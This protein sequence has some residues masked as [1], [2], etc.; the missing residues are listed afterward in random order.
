MRRHIIG[1]AKGLAIAIVAAIVIVGIRAGTADVRFVILIAVLVALL[2]SGSLYDKE[3]PTKKVPEDAGYDLEIVQ[4]DDFGS[5]WDARHAEHV[6]NRID[7]LSRTQNVFVVLFIH[8][9]HNN[10]SPRNG[11]LLDFEEA[12]KGIAA[13]MDKEQFA[14]LRERLTGQRGSKLVGVYVGWRGQSLP[15]PFDYATMWWRKDAAERVGNGDVGE[16]LERLQRSYLRA[17]STVVRENNPVVK[18]FM[19]LVTIGHSFGGQVLMKAISWR[20]ESELV[21]RTRGAMADTANPPS[22]A[23]KSRITQLEPIDSYGDV[24]ILLNPA[25]EAYQYARIDSLFRRI[26]YLPTQTPQLLVLSADNDWARQSFFPIARVLT[27]PFRP[28]F[29]NAYQGSLWGKALGELAGQQTHDLN[30][31]PDAPDSLTPESVGRDPGSLKDY[32]FTTETVFA[33]VKLSPRPNGWTPNSPVAVVYTHKNIIKEHNGIFNT[34]LRDFL[35]GY[36]AFLEAK[37]MLL[38][39][40]KL[41]SAASAAKSA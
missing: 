36:V 30:P 32:D 9:W 5:F 2:A 19:G 41:E 38:R 14:D 26:K 28:T 11:N 27:M 39:Q 18:P 15:M 4:V 16:F 22:T 12:L 33:Q 7:A 23:G 24:N 13:Q 25:L 17:N 35:I 21:M 8:G 37:R 31:A 3:W 29:R 10:A 40:E 1:T 34:G 6:A 20:I